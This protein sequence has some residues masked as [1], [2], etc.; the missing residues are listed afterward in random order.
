ML[1]NREQGGIA[2]GQQQVVSPTGQKLAERVRESGSVNSRVGCPQPPR[3]VPRPMHRGGAPKRNGVDR[4][5][6]RAKRATRRESS[7]LLPI[8]DQDAPTEAVGRLGHPVPTLA[9]LSDPSYLTICGAFDG[10]GRTR[11]CDRRIMSYVPGVEHCS[12]K[13]P[14]RP[15]DA[16]S[17]LKPRE[18]RAFP[19]SAKP[20]LTSISTFRPLPTPS[21]VP[22]LEAC[23][24]I[25]SMVMYSPRTENPPRSG[26][27]GTRGA[28]GAGGVL[29]GSVGSVASVASGESGEWGGWGESG[30]WGELGEWG[31][32]DDWG[33]WGGSGASDEWVTACGHQAAWGVPP[34]GHVSVTMSGH[35]R[36][37]LRS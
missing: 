34:W 19:H 30:E 3:A 5:S 8:R 20:M 36:A 12:A 9:S 7:P 11:T 18:G 23:S 15:G 27:S 16:L 25:V 37:S 13:D 6:S 29:D 22:R 17:R 35:A 1:G 10:P 32:S 2:R 21:S 28:G 31:A 26:R 14:F 33:G 24:P 4:V